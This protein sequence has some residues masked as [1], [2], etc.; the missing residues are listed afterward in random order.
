MCDKMSFRD[1]HQ[2]RDEKEL[3][4]AAIELMRKKHRDMGLIEDVIR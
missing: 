2:P 3:H 4:R 1:P